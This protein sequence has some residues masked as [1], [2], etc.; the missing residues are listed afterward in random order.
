MAGTELA[1][2]YISLFPKL[3]TN[4]IEA[5]L[6]GIKADGAGTTA[7][8]SFGES[9][10][11]AFKTIAGAWVVKEFAQSLVSL[12]KTALDSYA[13]FEQL[14]GGVEK[15]FDQMDNTQIF[16]DAA[17]AYKDLNMSAN[18]YLE[19]INS[20][21]AAFAATM[22][23][24]VGYTTA[25]KGMKA[26]ADYASGTGASIELLN[27]KFALISRSTSS[28]QSICDQF[29]GLLPQTNA[30]FLAQAQAAGIL[31]DQYTSLTEVP[32]AEYQQAIAEMLELGVEKAGLAGNTFAET[33]TTISGSLAALEASWS[34]WLTGLAD[35][36]A[37]VGK[38]TDQLIESLVTAAKNI[39]PRILQILGS[40]GDTLKTKLPELLDQLIASISSGGVGAGNAAAEFF[41]SI[42]LALVK[43]TPQILQALLL[44]LASLIVAIG[45]K[46]G[47]LVTQGVELM[48]G[49][50]QGVKDG[51]SHV[52]DE[53]GRGIDEGVQKIKDKVSDFIQAGKDLIA[54]LVEGI[55][56]APVDAVGAIG[57]V[58]TAMLNKALSVFDINSPSKAFAKIGEQN[59]EGLIVGTKNKASSAINAIGDVA[60]GALRAASFSATSSL[61][62]AGAGAGG[63]TYNIYIDGAR[64]NSDSAIEGKFYDLMIEL[65]R[66]AKMEGGE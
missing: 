8:T 28:Y 26:I 23:D 15:I 52:L 58:G 3:K 25:R 13:S 66:Y 18:E 42:L 53:I 10:K 35:D 63:T 50:A 62:T 1:S 49:F 12:S 5:Q 29:S 4:E 11:K 32:V 61:A 36:T 47:E 57:D 55:K 54:G 16:E 2:A 21:G 19:A 46:V 17:N 31:S 65:K 27:E 14:R 51:F 37:D 20:T 43:A 9:F 38:L 59:V 60:Q 22:G 6:K 24:E 34:N 39:A 33:E 48:K 64:V 40:L 45:N 56:T 30:D 44:L 7:G 41:G